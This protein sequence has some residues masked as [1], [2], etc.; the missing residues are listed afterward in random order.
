MLVTGGAGF[1]GSHLCDQLIEQSVAKLVAVDN[2]FLGKKSNLQ[3][4]SRTRKNFLFAEI[5]VT[6]PAAIKKIIDR[7]RIEVIFHLAVVPLEVS[8]LKP[9][10]CFT[11]NVKM[12]QN[13][14]EI[15][16]QAARPITLVAYSSSEVYGSARYAPMDENH[17]LLCHTPYAA[18]KL[19]SDVLVYSYYR[20]F[21]IDMALVRPFNNYGPRQNEGSYAGVIPITITRIMRGEKPIIYGDGKQ[22]RDF[23]FVGDTVAGTIKIYQNKKSRGEVF[24]LA[25]GQQIS[26]AKLIKTICREMNYRGEI[27]HRSERPGDVR[28][29]QGDASKAEKLLGFTPMVRFEEGIKKTVDWY[30]RRE[31]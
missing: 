16:R 23:I 15:I 31:I 21:G 11:Q 2:L 19:S 4:V 28:K 24:N 9:D 10:W 25:S 12:T 22:T 26:I 14:C 8:L 30:R 3:A 7:H 27:E 20:T 29:H 1:I 13:I 5:D 17:P 18:S 6:N